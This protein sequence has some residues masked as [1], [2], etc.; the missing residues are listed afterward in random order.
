MRDPLVSVYQ[1]LYAAITHVHGSDFMIY[2]GTPDPS[3]FF[4]KLPAAHIIYVSGTAEKA[5]MREY[6]PHGLIDNGDGTF[7]VGT[8]SC[9]FDYLIQVSFFGIKPG[10]AQQ[11]STRF[12]AFVEMDNELL[13]PDDKWGE[14][15]QVFITG[16]PTPPRGEPDLYQC[17]ATYRCRGKLI[18]EEEVA[19]IDI[20]NLKFKIR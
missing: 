2:D 16:P 19:K 17:D 8:E 10:I 5:L 7:T 9:R 3:E 4:K 20:T 1:S 18:T 14:I 11:L 15:M 6:E 12:L 13:I